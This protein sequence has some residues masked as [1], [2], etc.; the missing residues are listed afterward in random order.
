MYSMMYCIHS[1]T[2]V[3]LFALC[4]FPATLSY[5]NLTNKSIHFSDFTKRLTSSV[6]FSLY[7][8][9]EQ[10]FHIVVG[11][12]LCRTVSYLEQCLCAGMAGIGSGEIEFYLCSD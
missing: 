3:C 4:I 5:T 8:Y 2:A 7:Q 9:M 12:E 10:K 11:Q 6:A 1:S